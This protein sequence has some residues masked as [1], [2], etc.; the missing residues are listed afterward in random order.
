MSYAERLQQAATRV[1]HV[2]CLGIDPDLDRLGMDLTDAEAFVEALLERV[3]PA[4][5]KPNSAYFEVHG[6]RGIAWLER[7]IN[8]H[9]DTCPIILDAKRGDIGPSSRAYARA[10]FEHLRAD[11]VTVAP[12]MG[13]DSVEPFTRYAPQHGIYVLVRTS[14]PGSADLQARPLGPRPIWQHLWQQ[15]HDWP[16]GDH[17]GAVMGATAPE[18]LE[19]ACE[20]SPR[21]LLIP[22]VGTQGG[23]A[24]Q[25][26]SLLKRTP[27]PKIHRVNVSSAIL[28]AHEADKESTRL[29]ACTRAFTRHA[30]QLAL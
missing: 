24:A 28:Y 29:E 11:A 26:M 22:G 1:G 17:L 14:N 30:A 16:G 3:Q 21:P 13:R 9:R 10:A 6:S 19:W 25:V 18:D 12:Y 5:L 8:R 2:L 7:L 4:A 15:L 27:D 23:D 20:Q